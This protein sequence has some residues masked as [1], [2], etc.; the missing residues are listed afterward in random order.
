MWSVVER[1][2]K[3][4]VARAECFRIR[5]GFHPKVSYE[6]DS[7]AASKVLRHKGN[8]QLTKLSP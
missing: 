1:E 8:D 5:N 2:A 4:L 6:T 7:Y 3:A